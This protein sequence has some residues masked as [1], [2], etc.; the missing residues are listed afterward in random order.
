MRGGISISKSKEKII[1]HYCS[2]DA[3]LSII[4]N[5]E[6][7]ASD[8]FKMNDSLEEKCL[9]DLLRFYLKRIHGEL[10]KDKKF[11]E[12]LKKNEE[13]EQEELRKKSF[14]EYYNK[15]FSYEVKK[16]IQNYININ[17]FLAINELLKEKSKKIKRY[18]CCFSGDGDLLSQWRA[19]ADDGRGISVGFKKSQ[20]KDFLKELEVETINIGNKG[21]V[22]K[23]LK[24]KEAELVDIEY[25]RKIKN[26]SY[27]SELTKLFKYFPRLDFIMENKEFEEMLI[28]AILSNSK[29]NLY[30]DLSPLLRYFVFMIT[31]KI[32]SKEELKP[33][34]IKRLKNFIK[35]KSIS[36][37]EE[38][39][40]RIVIIE[41]ETEENQNINNIHFRNKNNNELVSYK[42]LKLENIVDFI[43]HIVLG[44][45]NKITVE[46]LKR[47]LIKQFSEEKIKHIIIEKSDIPYVN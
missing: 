35:V 21:E 39:E 27:N 8:I 25:K 2:V 46:E 31:K 22:R 38:K 26:S 33:Q 28:D 37:S 29:M 14:E 4:K 5:Q 20:I 32:F 44:P 17:K 13:E 7:W 43:S 3:F 1:Y 47:F 11:K 24:K 23:F 15:I 16:S 41:D 19:Y 42:K 10:L 36:F 12:Y 18:I 30:S 45:K 40:S 34:V 9:E 6:L